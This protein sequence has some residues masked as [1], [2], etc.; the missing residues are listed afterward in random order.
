MRKPLPHFLR[1][2]Q[3]LAL[4]GGIAAPS[5]AMLSQ[6]CGGEVFEPAPADAGYD[7][8]G[9]GVD[10]PYYYDGQPVGVAPAEGGGGIQ[11]VDGGFDGTSVGVSPYT[12]ASKK[13]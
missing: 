6:A 11:P 12:D 3:T 13:D 4:V 9:T 5:T 8:W 2:T 1:V 10:S 7:G